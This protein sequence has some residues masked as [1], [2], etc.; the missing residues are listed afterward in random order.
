MYQMYCLP[1]LGCHN[2]LFSKIIDYLFTKSLMEAMGF[3]GFGVLGFWQF[4]F[5]RFR[6]PVLEPN[7]A[8]PEVFCVGQ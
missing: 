1:F 6:F 5:G 4:R 3:W 7:R 2:R 8:L